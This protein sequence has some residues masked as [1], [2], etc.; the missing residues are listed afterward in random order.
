MNEIAEILDATAG[1]RLMWKIKDYP[2]I[3]FIDI[4]E[5]LEYQ[6]DQFMD[7]TNTDFPDNHFNL[8]FFDPP[9]NWGIPKNERIFT[10]PSKKVADEKFN[11]GR[12]YPSY[13]GLDKFDNKSGLINFIY[14]AQEEFKRILKPNGLLFFKWSEYKIPV[15]NIKCLFRDWIELMEIPLK[16]PPR[17]KNFSYWIIYAQSIK[18]HR[19]RLT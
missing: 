7:C 15:H 12:T 5:E 4:E 8:I 6:P 3:H 16:S 1:N 17:G 9:H 19:K 13:Y 18:K 10:I 14:E 2:G 11:Y